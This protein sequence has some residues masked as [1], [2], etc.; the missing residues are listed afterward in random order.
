MP[1]VTVRT[2]PDHDDH[3]QGERVLDVDD[4][5]VLLD[6]LTRAGVRVQTLCGGALECRTCVVFVSGDEASS[7]PCGVKER[8]LLRAKN[9]RVPIDLS[10]ARFACQVRV[11]GALTVVVP[12]PSARDD[13]DDEVLP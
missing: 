10:L 7:S 9:E 5:V 11:K 13:D 3:A 8:M 4:G 1:R 6:A 2:A 12:R